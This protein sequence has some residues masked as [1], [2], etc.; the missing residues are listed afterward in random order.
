MP[1]ISEVLA[2][3]I[4]GVLPVLLARDYEKDKA[5]QAAATAAAA[6]PASVGNVGSSGNVGAVTSMKKGGMSASKRADGCAIRG[7][8][9]GKMV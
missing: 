5:R 3:G 2:S 4:G 8:T 1:K 6:N 7:K 9:R